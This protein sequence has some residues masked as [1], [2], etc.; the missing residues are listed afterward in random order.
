MTDFILY[1]EEHCAFGARLDQRPRQK[2]LYINININTRISFRY[3]DILLSPF[4]LLYTQ[5]ISHTVSHASTILTVS[6]SYDSDQRLQ[7]TNIHTSTHLVESCNTT[8]TI[9]RTH[10]AHQAVIPIRREV[11]L[12]HLK[13]LSDCRHLKYLYSRTHRQR[14]E[15]HRSS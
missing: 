9:R 2:A 13:R 14:L 10:S 15:W 11:R 1:S 3:V 5:R 7:D 12:H 4:F 6:C 8:S